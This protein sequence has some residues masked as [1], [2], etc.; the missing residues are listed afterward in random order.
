MRYDKN[1]SIYAALLIIFVN[2]VTSVSSQGH[3]LPP[4][5]P[6]F[7]VAPLVYNN[8]NFETGSQY[9]KFSVVRKTGVDT[10]VIGKIVK[11]SF[12]YY[13]LSENKSVKKT[14][15]SRFIKIF[16]NKTKSIIRE[17]RGDHNF[18]GIAN[19]SCWLF[20]TIEG[21]INAYTDLAEDII[22]DS[23]LLYV[24]K[25]SGILI[26]LNE[27]NLDSLVLP[28]KRAGTLVKNKK[29]TKAILNYNDK[30]NPSG[31]KN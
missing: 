24:Q 10:I 3:Y 29:Y 5:N 23:H 7:G 2:A 6:N 30:I 27:E 11:D 9:H 8:Y 17:D 28:V 31:W 14:D 18:L 13:L 20:K 21:P 12:N 4:V 19:D 22:E 1:F 26:T 25:D 15:S 16:P